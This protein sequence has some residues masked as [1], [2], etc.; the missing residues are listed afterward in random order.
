MDFLLQQ[1]AFVRE[2]TL[3]ELEG[4]T[5]EDANRIPDGFQNSIRWHAG[6]IYFVSERLGIE[7]AGQPAR[8][9]DGFAEW[10]AHGTKPANW[11]T[12]PPILKELIIQLR[13]QPERVQLAL[14]GRL[15]DA[16]VKPY[17]N[18][19]GLKMETI[20]ELV[21]C[22]LYHEGQ[23]FQAIKTYKKLLGISSLL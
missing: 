18:S 17:T 11:D 23:H 16:A 10:F 14:N 6:H 7:L 20:G 9:M 3:L 1:F 5:E 19:S 8:G 4:I 2:K 15:N 21:S 22:M 13:T 12:N